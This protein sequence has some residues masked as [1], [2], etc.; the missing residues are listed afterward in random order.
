[1]KSPHRDTR[2]IAY[3]FII[4]M[5]VVSLFGDITYEGARSITGP[6][7]AL[8][9]ASATV[10]GVAAGLGELIG[11]SLRLASGFVAEKT[12]R[13]WLIALSGYLINLVSIPLLSSAGSWPAAASLMIAERFGK[14]VRTPA[15]D[16][17][18]S[19]ATTRVGTGWGFGVHQAMDQTG[20][21]IGSLPPW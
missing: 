9:G 18:L 3:Q 13:Y 2:R 4:M 19:H 12:G 14:A 6:F 15:R 5:G 17:M 21:L 1:M 7:L 20:S 10:V 16:S 11:Y 8:L